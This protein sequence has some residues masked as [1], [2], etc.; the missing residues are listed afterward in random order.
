ME[1]VVRLRKQLASKA[2]FEAAATALEAMLERQ[3]EDASLQGPLTEA[4]LR[5]H[6]VLVSR[7]GTDAVGHWRAGCRCVP[8]PRRRWTETR[9]AG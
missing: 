4:A 1:E 2:S 9:P 3:W 5:T 6:T 7:F 8:N